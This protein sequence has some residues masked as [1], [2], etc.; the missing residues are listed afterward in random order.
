MTDETWQLESGDDTED[1]MAGEWRRQMR[2]RSLALETTL[3]S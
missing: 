2:L 1:F 3:E